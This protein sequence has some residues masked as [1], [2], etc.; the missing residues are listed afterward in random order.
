MSKGKNIVIRE[1]DVKNYAM[2]NRQFLENMY[3]V[4]DFT[5]QNI[6][7]DIQDI[8]EPI[9]GIRFQEDEL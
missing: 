4:H 5:V 2:V 1:D 7:G 3:S 9:R 8:K 6:Y